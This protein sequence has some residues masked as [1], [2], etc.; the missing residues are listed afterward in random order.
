MLREYQKELAGP[1]IEGKNTIICAPTNSGK[2]YVAIEIAKR[3]LDSYAANPDKSDASGTSL[4]GV[5][6]RSS[7]SISRFV[8]L[9]TIELKG[10]RHSNSVLFRTKI[11]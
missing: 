8:L 5:G 10:V 1:A 2:T 9:Y 3:H 6:F 11:L 7:N 4:T